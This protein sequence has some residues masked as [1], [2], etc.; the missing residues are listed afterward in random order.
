MSLLFI[1]TFIGIDR[2]TLKV[3]IMLGHGE[4]VDFLVEILNPQFSF[5]SLVQ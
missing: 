4:D 3:V 1:I 5:I 2:D